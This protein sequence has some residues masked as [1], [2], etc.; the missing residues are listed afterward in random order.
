MSNVVIV[1][2]P[3]ESEMLTGQTTKDLASGD[4][5]IQ[6]IIAKELDV[7]LK[8]IR[9]RYEI[10]L[11][12]RFFEDA[13]LKEVGQILNITKESVRQLQFKAL[14]QMKNNYMTI[15]KERGDHG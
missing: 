9:P 7:A 1:A 14:R 2:I 5:P 13:T 10:V 3:Y 6:L 11:R 15:G 8:S 4:M 12:K